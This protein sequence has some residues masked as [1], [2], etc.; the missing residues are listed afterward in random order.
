VNSLNKEKKIIGFR[1]EP[2]DV[3]DYTQPKIQDINN[4]ITSILN[5]N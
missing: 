5:E 3:D 1:L 4:R 2:F